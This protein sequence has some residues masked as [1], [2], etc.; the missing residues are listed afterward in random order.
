MAQDIV[1]VNTGCANIASIRFALERLKVTVTL[2][3]DAERIR[4][5][6]KVFLPGVGSANAAMS[7]IRSKQLVEC[8]QSLQQ[9]VLGICLGMQL[10]VEHSEEG[11]DG[12]TPCLSLIPGAVKRLSVGELRA[13]HMGW[14][15]VDPRD[16]QSGLFKGI[17]AGEYFYFV[18]SFAIAPYQYTLAECEYGQRFSAAIQKDNFMGVQFH[19]ERSG[20]AGAQLLQNFVDM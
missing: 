1:I 19:P 11:K 16:D 2:S 9:P 12:S 13:P 7:S 20:K 6:D 3:D 18:H 17:V 4:R 14:N 10:M 8:V 5:A 15:R